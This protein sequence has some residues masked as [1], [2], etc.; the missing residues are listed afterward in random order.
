MHSSLLK[1]F[2]VVV[3]LVTFGQNSAHHVSHGHR[4]ASLDGRDVNSPPPSE[5]GTLSFANPTANVTRAPINNPPINLTIELI[6]D[7][8]NFL[9]CTQ[10]AP[11][12]TTPKVV[13]F[14]S[15]VPDFFISHF[16]LRNLNGSQSGITALTQLISIGKLL[17][18]ITSTAFIAQING[19]TFGGGQ[20]LAS[21]MDMRFA[22]PTP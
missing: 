13:I 16:D 21:Q 5:H 18:S 17:Q 20:E 15:T 3:S 10:P 22:G 6:S 7:L 9:L 12:K 11:Q 14:S 19:R 4:H 1:S 2:V 8:Y